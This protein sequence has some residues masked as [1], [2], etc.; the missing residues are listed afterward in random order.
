MKTP[1]KKTVMAPPMGPRDPRY[2]VSPLNS[3]PSS[4]A[5]SQKAGHNWVS[6]MECYRGPQL[7]HLQV[8]GLLW[9]S[10][11]WPVGPR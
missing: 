7:C 10:V 9:A 1:E 8:L 3:D 6:I 4:E 2:E 11:W 5:C